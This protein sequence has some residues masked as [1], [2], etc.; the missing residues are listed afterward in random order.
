MKRFF[1][2]LAALVLSVSMVNASSNK[3]GGKGGS[4]G[5]GGAKSV[6]TPGNAKIGNTVNKAVD[7]KVDLGGKTQ[8]IGKKVGDAGKTLVKKVGK[9]ELQGNKTVAKLPGFKS[10]P[11]VHLQFCGKYKLPVHLHSHCFFHHDFCWNHH[12]W[13]PTFGCCGYWHPHAR[14]WYYWHETYCCYL[15]CSY[16]ETYP[17]VVV[18]V[19]V[20]VNS[21]NTNTNVDTDA[22]PMLPPGAS[23]ALPPGVNPIIPAPK[24]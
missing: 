20:N 9:V 4:P 10:N 3:G 11:A 17:P 14:C 13:F 6:P 19:N 16:I 1:F 24:Q 7:K 21:T 15:P 22:P 2:I 5:A 23:Q 18:N 12:C 8:V